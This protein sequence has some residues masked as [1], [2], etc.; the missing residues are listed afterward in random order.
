MTNHRIST[1]ALR[2][3]ALLLLL[4]AALG[5]AA[6]GFR[7]DPLKFSQSRP[8]LPTATD[9]AMV[10]L[11][12]I[13]VTPDSHSVGPVRVTTEQVLQLINRN[14]IILLD[15]RSLEDYQ[16]GHLP[17]AKS[18]P[19]DRVYE[20]M[21]TIEHLPRDRWIV[22]YCGGPPCDLGELLAYELASLGLSRVAVYESGLDSWI[23]SGHELETGV[24]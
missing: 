17:N 15:A 12:V 13:G 7:P 10:E 21:D 22:C 6:N 5:I 1:T 8:A 11:P 24:E 4:A 2:E 3:A 16:Q 19:F 14:N 20:H 23:Q 9:S 18:L